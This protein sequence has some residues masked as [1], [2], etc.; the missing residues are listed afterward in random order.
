MIHHDPVTKFH[1]GLLRHDLS[2]KKWWYI[3]TVLICFSLLIIFLPIMNFIRKSTQ[4]S[5]KKKSYSENIY[6]VSRKSSLIKGDFKKLLCNQILQWMFSWEFVFESS[7]KIWKVFLAP[8][9]PESCRGL[10]I[11]SCEIL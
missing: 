4:I 3:C 5:S 10:F 2:L 11:E 8:S 9:L 6:D 1:S 7:P